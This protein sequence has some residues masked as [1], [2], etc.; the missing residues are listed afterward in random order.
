MQKTK[1]KILPRG[2]AIFLIF[3]FCG[4]G[5]QSSPSSRRVASVVEAQGR[6]PS[7]KIQ[8]STFGRGCSQIL[9]FE[10]GGVGSQSAGRSPS[11]RR[12]SIVGRRRRFFL[13]YEKVKKKIATSGLNRRRRRVGSGLNRRRRRSPSSRR[14]WSQSSVAVV[15]CSLQDEKVKIWP[16]G[17]AT[18]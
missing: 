16:R 4:V 5:S 9:N 13:Q 17:A 14:V 3:Y 8:N 15:M 10:F 12:V 18:F 6:K 7:C 1:F 11:S 2:A